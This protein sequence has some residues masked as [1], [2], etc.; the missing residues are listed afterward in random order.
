[1]KILEQIIVNKHIEETAKTVFSYCLARTH[2]KEEAEDLSQDILLEILKSACNLRDEKVFYNFMWAIANNVYKNWCKKKIKHRETF[3]ELDDKLPDDNENL[4]SR[5]I[6]NDEINLLRRELSLLSEKYRTAAVLYYSRDCS[7]SKVAQS[8]S[9]SENMVKYLLFKARKILKE[10]IGMEREFGEKSYNPGKFE[11]DIIYSGNSNNEYNNLLKRKIPGNILLS[12]YY[13]PLTIRELSIELGISSAYMEDEIS[14]L[15]KYDLIKSVGECKYQ[16][17]I[18]I[19]TMDYIKE[20]FKM[21]DKNY[22]AKVGEIIEIIKNLLPEVRK[23]GFRGCN[24]PDNNLLWSLYTLAIFNGSWVFG[25]T[26]DYHYSKELYKGTTGFGSGIDHNKEEEQYYS[27]GMAGRAGGW[28]DGVAF[29]YGDFSVLDYSISHNDSEVIHQIIKKSITDRDAAIFPVFEETGE[30]SEYDK[31]YNI[32]KHA[33]DKMGELFTEAANESVKIMTAH[34]P[35]SA[36]DNIK[37]AIYNTLL[38]KLLGWFG[39]TAINLN[40]LQ[41]PGSDEI[42]QV[43]GYIK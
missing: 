40:A 12:A 20:W 30:P 23:I 13:T 19:F 4:D 38:F 24:I 2:S 41:K 25:N 18:I 31:A 14:I 26:H 22:T 17:N 5:L 3:Y 16:T 43:Y 37:P 11:Y 42:V 10:G 33:I 1:M 39:A 35:K 15:E 7:V 6:K 9:I 8:L 32:L 36:A 21:L 27:H 28:G 29:T 34:A